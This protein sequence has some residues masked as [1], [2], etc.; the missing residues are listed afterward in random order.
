MDSL[1]PKTQDYMRRTSCFMKNITIPKCWPSCGGH[2]GIL[3]I[4]QLP[5]VTRVNLSRVKITPKLK[6]SKKF[7]G[8]NILGQPLAI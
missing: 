7:K 5:N 4:K 3:L 6:S 2:L 8:N 1:T